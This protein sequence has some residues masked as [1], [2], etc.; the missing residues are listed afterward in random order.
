ML[1]AP[2]ITLRL[3]TLANHPTTLTGTR[4]RLLTLV[5]LAVLATWFTYMWFVSR[6]VPSI[7]KYPGGAIRA[8]GYAQRRGFGEY[9]K[10][11]HWVTYHAGSTPG[12]TGPKESEGMY[13][14]GQ[15]DGEWRYWDERGALIRVENYRRGSPAAT[16]PSRP[17]VP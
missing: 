3:A 10:T 4:R 5:P 14:D 7:D 1:A 13:V 2:R 15:K 17:S 8:E 6:V 16:A 12:K 11:G 9:M